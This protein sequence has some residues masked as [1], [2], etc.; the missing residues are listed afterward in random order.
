KGNRNILG[1]GW[2]ANEDEKGL[3]NDDIKTNTGTST[4][5]SIFSFLG[6]I[7]N[8]EEGTYKW[9]EEQKKFIRQN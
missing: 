2:L 7:Q 8:L 6:D 1:M 3:G 9:D 4:D 5:H